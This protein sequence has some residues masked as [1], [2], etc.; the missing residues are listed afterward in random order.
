MA[1]LRLI[2]QMQTDWMAPQT[3]SLKN[4]NTRMIIKNR[5]GQ[6]QITIL[7]L[8]PSSATANSYPFQAEAWGFHVDHLSSI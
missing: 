6:P 4:S 1:I 2:K 7:F 5:S 8:F 3:Q